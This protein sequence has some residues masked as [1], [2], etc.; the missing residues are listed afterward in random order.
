MAAKQVFSGGWPLGLAMAGLAGLAPGTASA[1]FEA[2]PYVATTVEYDDNVFRTENE[3]ESEIRLQDPEQADVLTKYQAG[4]ETQYKVGLQRFFLDAEVLEFKY[5]H[6]DNLDNSGHEVAGGM[7]WKV[8]SALNGNLKLES[9][10]R[11]QDFTNIQV[12]L[13]NPDDPGGNR[14]ELGLQKYANAVLN[15]NLRLLRDYELRSRFRAE[16]LR[17][18]LLDQAEQLNRDERAGAV[19]LAYLGQGASSIGLEAEYTSGEY[20]D[21][22][23]TGGLA[24][25]FDQIVYQA[26]AIWVFSDISRFELQLGFTD[27]DNQGGFLNETTGEQ[28]DVDDYSG[29]TGALYYQRTISAKTAVKGGFQRRSYSVDQ[30]NQ[31]FVVI[32]GGDINLTWSPTRKIIFTSSYANNEADFR[33]AVGRTDRVQTVALKAEYLPR[34]W[35]VLTPALTWEDRISHP[36]QEEEYE[37]FRVGLEVRLRLPIR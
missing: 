14:P 23:A 5:D 6:Y 27:R 29:T 37:D 30:E 2:F 25:E 15:A 11:V 34:D 10:R 21:R 9:N 16:R 12:V 33:G 20:I 35:L 28:V 3:A 1:E 13:P 18:T 24:E 19:G 36:L 4:I 22:P 7:D 31:N 32:T 26:I 8:G 17:H